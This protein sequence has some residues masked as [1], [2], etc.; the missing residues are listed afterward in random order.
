MKQAETL[1]AELAPT[2][3]LHEKQDAGELRK[4]VEAME[5]LARAIPAHARKP[6][7]RDLEFAVKGIV[8]QRIN[9]KRRRGTV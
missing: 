6:W 5:A 2:S 8:R 4:R 1:F 9:T 3:K 7:K